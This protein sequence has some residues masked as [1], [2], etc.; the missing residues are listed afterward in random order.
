MKRSGLFVLPRL[1]EIHVVLLLAAL[2]GLLGALV[3]VA[4]RIAIRHVEWVFTGHMS[5]LVE[6]AQSLVWWQRLTVPVIGGLVAGAI[7]QFG[8]RLVRGRPT[9]DYM[10]AVAVG[11]G[12]LGVRTSLVK[13]ASSLVTIGS[14]GSIG[15]E[16][17]MVQLA[18]LVGSVTGRL[19]PHSE[20]RMRLLVACGAAAGMASA[21]NA[22]IAGA[23]FVAE[24]VL[25]SIAMESLGPMLVSS[26]V[27][28]ATVH[29]LLGYAPVFA[30]P[31]LRFV[32]PWETLFYF[33]L[34]I[35]CG[36]AA[37]LFLFVLTEVEKGF[38]SLALPLYGK[39][40][41]GGLVVGVLSVDRP[42]IWGNGYSVVT[43]IIHARLAWQ[44]VAVVL[45]LKVVATAA[46]AGSGAAGGV[47]TPTIFV[48]ASLGFLLGSG[49]HAAFPGVTAG[50]D[51]YAV[52]GMG[53]LLAATTHAPVM[54]I[55][56]IFEMTLDY[57]IV[58]PLMLGCV[59]AYYVS[60]SHLNS[61]SIYA[62]SLR[63]KAAERWAGRLEG[64]GVR[65]FVETEAPSVAAG[66]DLDAL[67][68]RMRTCREESVLVI[69]EPDTLVGVL[70]AE[71]VATALAEHE[72]P[73][74]RRAADLATRDHPFLTP[75]LSLG[76]ALQVFA[77]SGAAWLPVIAGAEDRRLLGRVHKC[78]I[79]QALAD[80]WQRQ[81]T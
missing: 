70:A 6:A 19:L 58:L 74:D 34:G 49:V 72:R 63:S 36:V 26:V 61:E 46:T 76:A 23:L 80:D 62:R 50:P 13:S 2:I 30:I 79:F 60:R 78:A 48:G 38:A 41:L 17:S 22:P 29:N 18:A 47:F 5:G 3:T 81:R 37:P 14:G 9:T 43:Q 21:Y 56:M 25:G 52:V 12:V 67:I 44:L 68:D 4:F 66:A 71:S 1:R 73:G 45:V 40:A 33:A 15:R 65:D 27:A 55:L 28:S 59:T 35:V 77:R 64:L 20:S 39:M 69:A 24:I 57:D 51:T 32:S 42:E 54:S 75:D 8:L 53:A 11:D 10:E 7:L 31:P 16:G